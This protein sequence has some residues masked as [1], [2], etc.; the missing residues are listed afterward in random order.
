MIYSGEEEALPC[1]AMLLYRSPNLSLEMLES[2]AIDF[3]V[4]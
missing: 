4:Y 2:G 3:I 1:W